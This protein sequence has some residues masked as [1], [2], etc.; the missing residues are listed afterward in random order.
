MKSDNFARLKQ[1]SLIKE[2]EGK[3]L[4]QRF[5]LN[6][7]EHKRTTKKIERLIINHMFLF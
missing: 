4:F 6:I 5:F 1:M 3:T 7:L 2:E